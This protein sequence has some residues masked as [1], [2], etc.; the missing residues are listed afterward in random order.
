[1]HI[2]K[3]NMP[4]IYLVKVNT[5]YLVFHVKSPRKSVLGISPLYQCE[6]KEVEGSGEHYLFTYLGHF[7]WRII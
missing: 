2:D 7:Y 4:V 6:R 3:I 1:M 5:F